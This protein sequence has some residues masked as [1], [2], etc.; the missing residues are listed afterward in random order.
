[1]STENWSE[2]IIIVKLPV[3]PQTSEELQAVTKI[4]LDRPD[5]DLIMDFSNVEEASCLSLC[6]LMKLHKILTDHGQRLI[7][8][9]VT[10]ATRGILH[11]YAFDRIFE[12]VSDT[13]VALKPPTQ[14]KGTGMLV[15][16]SPDGAEPDKRRNYV[17]LNICKIMKLSV[18]L[19]HRREKED[20]LDVPWDNCWQGRIV[21][22]SEGGAQIAVDATRSP[23]FKENNF[24]R[25]QFAPIPYETALM[26][27]AQIRQI[28]PA[29]EN[30]STC[31]GVQFIGLEANPEG[32]QSLRWLCN[33]EERYYQAKEFTTI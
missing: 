23:D 31:L 11:T 22:I 21:D 19:W 33:S 14:V 10:A 25:L 15:F 8:C 3:E 32:R 12:V 16:G 4:A 1:M 5:C 9:N 26:F 13:Q 29:G 28:L 2:D 30:N 20:N 7:L 18:L 27:D 6:I 24:I 17:R